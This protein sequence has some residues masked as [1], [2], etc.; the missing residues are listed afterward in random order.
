MKCTALPDSSTAMV[1]ICSTCYSL[2]QALIGE[3]VTF[4][5]PPSRPYDQRFTYTDEY[6]VQPL[7]FIA[8]TGT[9]A[10]ERNKNVSKR[11]RSQ[12]MRNYVWRQNHPTTTDEM[13]A[14][15]AVPLKVKSQQKYEGKFR[16]GSRP[17]KAKKS[18]KATLAILDSTTTSESEQDQE[19]VRKAILRYSKWSIRQSLMPDKNLLMRKGANS[20]PFNAFSFPMG[21]ES[22]QYIF[23]CEST[24]VSLRTE[25]IL[26]SFSLPDATPL[27]YKQSRTDL[28]HRSKALCR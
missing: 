28:S 19:S 22:E 18:A 21:P 25:C 10:D 11:I 14:A 9:E 8:V 23:Y 2:C 15:A 20:D 26:A 27:V 17:R 4:N 24:V 6:D 7:E 16:I 13:A 1:C 12:A 3:L 5:I